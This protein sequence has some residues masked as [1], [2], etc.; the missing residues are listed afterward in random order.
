VSARGARPA[1][2][3]QPRSAV[4]D[5]ALQVGQIHRVE[6]HD[7]ERADTRGREIQG[8]G[9]PQ[10][11]RTHTKHSGCLEL[12]LAFESTSGNRRWRE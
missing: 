9:G 4:N 2:A 8:Q 6:V 10:S 12:P 5:L 7:S 1:S 11:A 3:Y